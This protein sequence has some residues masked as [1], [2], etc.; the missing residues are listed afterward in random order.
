MNQTS[1]VVIIGGGVTGCAAAYYLSERGVSCTIVESTDIASHASGYA[2]GGLNP[3]E[4]YEIPGLLSEFA[5]KA[6]LMHLE[7]WDKDMTKCV[8]KIISASCKYLIKFFT[9]GKIIQPPS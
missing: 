1:D 9:L 6:Y 8:K 5:M 2:A 3:L 7:L 4:G